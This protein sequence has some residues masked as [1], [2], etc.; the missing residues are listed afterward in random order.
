MSKKILVVDDSPTVRQQVQIALKIAASRS[1]RQ[2]T[3]WRHIQDIDGPRG[4]PGIL[5]VK[6][7]ADERPGDAEKVKDA[8]RS[9]P[10]RESCSRVRDN[11][12]SSSA[13]RKR[14][15][16]AGSQAVKAELLAAAVRKLL[17]A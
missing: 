16:R 14:A 15:R 13:R 12:H 9:E 8:A 4:R 6:H 2:A 11:K 3:A 7:A 5:D 10:A 1:W 17:A